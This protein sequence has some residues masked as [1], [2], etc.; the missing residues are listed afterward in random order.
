MHIDLA[1]NFFSFHLI[2]GLSS[3]RGGL[4][5]YIMPN[6]TINLV[7]VIKM[8]GEKIG[9]GCGKTCTIIIIPLKY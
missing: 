3:P 6:A 4:V 5:T 7:T 2:S 9:S 1:I 8:A